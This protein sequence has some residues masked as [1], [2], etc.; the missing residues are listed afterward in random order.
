MVCVDSSGKK[1]L[2]EIGYSGKGASCNNPCDQDKLNYGPIPRGTYTVGKKRPYKKST[3][4]P[5]VPSA[6]TRKN[7]PKGRNPD[8]FLIHGDN[9]IGNKS[10]SQGCIILNKGQGRNRIPD[11][12][13]LEVIQ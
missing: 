9:I 11:G 13:T 10:A 4:R 8:S 5:L 7:F 3:S 12:E 2:D 6:K 1:Y